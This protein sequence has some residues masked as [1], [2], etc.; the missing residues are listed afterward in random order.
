MK[1]LFPIFF[2]TLFI[3]LFSFGNLQA[4]ISLKSQDRVQEGGKDLVFT[5]VETEAVFPGGNAAWKS[6]IIDYIQRSNRSIKGSGT[7]I[8]RFIVD[9]DGN[10]SDAEATTLQ[11]SMLAEIAVDAIK[12]SPKW[13]PAQQNGRMVKAWRLQPVTVSSTKKKRYLPTGPTSNY[14]RL[15]DIKKNTLLKDYHKILIFGAGTA[16]VRL[17]IDKLDEHLAT[18]L[19][20]KK[21]ESSHYFLGS[22]KEMAIEKSEQIAKSENHDAVMIFTQAED[23]Y[24]RE[25]IFIEGLPL[26]DI[27]AHQTVAVQLFEISDR[28]HPVWAAIIQMNFSLTSNKTYKKISE[29][30][31]K[32]MYENRIWN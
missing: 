27:K 32:S 20:N 6:Y 2:F 1:M 26:R 4:Q 23:S 13:I 15:T 28:D 30:I 16:P 11:G 14:V 17:V 7:C 21:I 9:K 10:I 5:K 29:Q 3:V 8:V 19:K 24:L 18:E 25:T 22:D 12:N 31:L